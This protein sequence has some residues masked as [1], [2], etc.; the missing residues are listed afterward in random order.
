M[1]VLDS[2]ILISI[3]MID[4]LGLTPVKPVTYVAVKEVGISSDQNAMY[5][6][7]MEVCPRGQLC[8]KIFRMNILL[9]ISLEEM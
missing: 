7:T 8:L 4:D 2:K 5:R 3:A 9:L 6:R 1:E